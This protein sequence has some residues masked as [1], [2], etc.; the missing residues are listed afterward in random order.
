MAKIFVVLLCKGT[1]LTLFICD[2]EKKKVKFYCI[3]MIRANKWIVIFI[4]LLS[5]FLLI[6]IWLLMV[7]VN[8]ALINL[9]ENFNRK[10]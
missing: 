2:R 8:I 6:I 1:C 4:L 7:F 10:K 9:S 3:S 5:F